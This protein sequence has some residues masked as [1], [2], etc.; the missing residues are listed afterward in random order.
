MKQSIFVLM[1]A[2]F[3]FFGC[4]SPDESTR[5]FIPGTYVKEIKDEFT[6]GMDTLTIKVLDYKSY[7]YTIT[8]NTSYSQTIDGKTLPAKSDMHKWI[9]V[10]R[11]T[12]MQLIEQSQG[13]VFT[14]SPERNVLSM[15]SSVYRKI[16]NE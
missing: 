15:G 7:N 12:T 4:S 11:P 16:S 1:I 2:C 6:E 3:A 14:F 10:F 5:L 13:R 8:R 9:A